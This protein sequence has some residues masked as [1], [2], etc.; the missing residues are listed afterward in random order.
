[1]SLA[2]IQSMKALKLAKQN[3][4][5]LAESAQIKGTTQSIVFNTDGTVQKVQHKD[6]LSNVLREDVFTYASNLITEVRTLSSGGSITFKYH[7]DTLETEV[8]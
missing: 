4:A 5:S 8:L 6:P 1:M 3:A 7:L 2:D